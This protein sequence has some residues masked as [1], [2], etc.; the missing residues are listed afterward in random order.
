MD[1]LL[2]HALT[3]RQRFKSLL[4]VV[5]QGMIS[6]DTQAML[7][8]FG[9]YYN[10]FPE[11][12][13]IHIDELQSLIRLKA[14]GAS[15]EQIA[16]TMH[17]SEQLR[18]PVDE[19]SLRGIL[20]QLHELDLSGKAGA[21]ITKYNN[22]EEVNLAYEL[23]KLSGLAVRSMAQSAPDDYIDTPIADL[24]AEISNDKGVKFRRIACLRESIAGM[25]GGASIAIAARPDKGKTSFIASVI[26]DFAPQ[27]PEYFGPDRPILWLNNEGSGK[28]IIP[29]V[30][31]AALQADLPEIIH[32]SNQGL[33]V[34]KYTEAVGGTADIIRVKDMHGASLA[35]IE[36]VVESMRPAVVVF[37]M[38]A[39]FRLGGTANGA[40]K[41]DMIEQMWQSVREMAVL[42]DFIALSTVQISAEGDDQFYPPYSALK[43]SKTGVQGA[44]DVILMLGSKHAIEYNS[45]RGLSTPKNKFAVAGKPSCVMAEVAF[46][47]AKCAFY[48]GSQQEKPHVP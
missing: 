8:W 28:R 11:H 5:P 2:L 22:G 47:G 43:D 10:T 25:M 7:A 40:N 17:L 46:D 14:A 21:L 41:A 23:N 13:F 12:D 16:I 42:H 48:D 30:Y 29:R 6:Q 15:Q 24:L 33:L 35:Q 44:T 9:A 31:Q 36:Q 19:A 3:N 18:K 39:N 38:L 4:H 34:P 32:L 45:L 27:L 26:T 20:G 37:D 1:L